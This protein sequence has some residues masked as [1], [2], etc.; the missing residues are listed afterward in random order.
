MSIDLA[1][2][3]D[4]M[5]GHARLLDRRRFELRGAGGDVAAV[6]GAVAGYRNPDGGYGWGLE[7]DLRSPESQPGAA[8]HAFEVFAEVAP[9]TTPDAAALCDWLEAITLPDGGLP[10]VLP[11]TTTAASAPWWQGVDSTVSSLQL[12]AVTAAAAQ[13]VA[14]HD[15][16][17]AGHRWLERATDY[18]LREIA[19]LD[20]APFAYVL[21]F[22]IRVLD[23][24]VDQRPETG[25]LLR[26]LARYVPAD[27]RIPVVGGAEGEQLHPLDVAPYPDRPA[28][29]M[30]SREVIAADLER[31]AALQQ[32]D[33]GWTV[34]YLK[35]SPAGA[36]EWRGYTTVRALDILRANGQAKAD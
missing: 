7:P 16:A 33:G 5:A 19:A 20:G 1:A 36:L 31:L 3:A 11:L 8:W 35:I 4:F 25:E 29:E 6:L 32:P 24:I 14:R 2:A 28:R 15:P 23:A 21:S 10:F 17:V 12:T 22:S 34:D 27:G 18:C 30:F 9:A 26:R 13:A